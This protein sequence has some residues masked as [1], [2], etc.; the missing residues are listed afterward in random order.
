MAACSVPDCDRPISSRGWCRRH[1]V[2]WLRTGDPLTVRR[3][4]PAPK[5]T[6]CAVEGCQ[7]VPEGRGMC[8]IHYSRWRFHGDP[9]VVL[10]PGQR[11]DP[12]KKPILPPRVKGDLLRWRV[13]T[14]RIGRGAGAPCTISSGGVPGRVRADRLDLG[15][16]VDVS[17][18]PHEPRVVFVGVVWR[19]PEVH[20]VHHV[21]AEIF[22][23]EGSGWGY[24]AYGAAASRS[25]EAPHGVGGEDQ[26]PADST[27]V[28]PRSLE[29]RAF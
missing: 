15:E 2:R 8:R 16:V 10:T 28:A 19:S 26:R 29:T 6:V 7:G 23:R 22:R 17:E 4:G 1:Y 11:R 14:G 9:L 20:H 24:W 27:G 18:P 21:H 12:A 13:A 3:R 5:A 25:K